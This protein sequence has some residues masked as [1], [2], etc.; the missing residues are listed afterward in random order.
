MN[1][2][3]FHPYCL[4]YKKTLVP[5][6]RDESFSWFHPNSFLLLQK[7]FRYSDF[8]LVYPKRCIGRVRKAVALRWFFLTKNPRRGSRFQA[9]K[10]T[11]LFIPMSALTIR[12]LCH[13][14]KKDTLF[15][16]CQFYRYFI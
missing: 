1:I 7:P 2:V 13:G 11:S 16:P 4:S 12:T 15:L 8:H 3:Y 9:Q 6:K 14:S 10:C 5:L